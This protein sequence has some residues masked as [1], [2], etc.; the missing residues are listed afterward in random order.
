MINAVIAALAGVNV[1]VGVL[2]HPQCKRENPRAV[3][4]LF[5]KDA[6]RW[7]SLAAGPPVSEAPLPTSWTVAFDGRSLGRITTN[8]PGWT[9]DYPWTYPRDRVLNLVGEG[10]AMP[11]QK[12]LFGG[13]CEAP[14]DRPLV[15]V[16]QANVTDPAGWRRRDAPSDMRKRVFPSFKARAGRQLICRGDTAKGTD[17]DYSVR[18]LTL[19]AT[20]GDRQGRRLV[21]VSLDPKTNSCDGPAESAWWPNWFMIPADNRPPVFLGEGLWLVD[22]GDYDRDG[23]SELVFWFSGYNRDGYVLFADELATRV[24]YLWNYH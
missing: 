1:L 18:D 7:T 8:D 5:A 23:R 2:E 15:V 21:G 19:L 3:R 13:W 4:V 9:S 12:E 17:F 22:A 6:S 14:A 20:Y 10:P 24:E 16:S 11:N